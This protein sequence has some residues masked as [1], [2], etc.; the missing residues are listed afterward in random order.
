M[1]DSSLSR[2]RAAELDS[3]RRVEQARAEAEEMIASAHREGQKMVEEARREGAEAA[4]RHYAQRVAEAESAAHAIAADVRIAEVTAAVTPKIPQ[5][6]ES[7]VHL[8][9]WAETEGE[10]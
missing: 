9:L 10:G 4:G 2:I 1:T 3:A 6:V 8:V 5:L 7:M